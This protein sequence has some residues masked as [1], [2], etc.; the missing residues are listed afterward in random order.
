MAAALR[1]SNMAETNP[2]L[3]SASTRATAS[4][5]APV[6]SPVLQGQLNTAVADEIA[7]KDRLK[8]GAV[9]LSDKIAELAVET[10]PAHTA[11]QEAIRSKATATSQALYDAITPEKLQ[12]QTAELTSEFN[13]DVDEVQKQEAELQALRDTTIEKDG[14]FSALGALLSIPYQKAKVGA[15][16]GAA[17][18][19]AKL[20]DT[21]REVSTDAA[22]TVRQMEDFRSEAIIKKSNDAMIAAAEIDNAARAEKVAT[23]QADLLGKIFEADDKM[24]NTLISA[25]QAE[26]QRMA[27]GAAGRQEADMR[28][29]LDAKTAGINTFR[30]SQGQTELTADQ[31]Q[32]GLESQDEFS[33]E[34]NTQYA[35]GV[36]LLATGSP[37]NTYAEVIMRDA[38]YT[39]RLATNI[40][41][42]TAHSM[43]QERAGRNAAKQQIDYRTAPL[44]LQEQL[45]NEAKE[46]VVEDEQERAARG[47]KSMYSMQPYD[48]LAKVPAIA[49]DPVH[50]KVIAPLKLEKTDLNEIYKRVIAA[51][52]EKLITINEAAGYLEKLINTSKLVNNTVNQYERYKMPPQETVPYYLRQDAGPTLGEDVRNLF[53]LAPSEDLRIEDISDSSSIMNALIRLKSSYVARARAGTDPQ[54]RY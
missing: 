6:A 54:G 46:E 26:S 16:E 15:A 22:T 10:A 44:E 20:I 34:L 25:Q 5:R 40:P 27:I 17:D 45:L 36:N 33:K 2:I 49:D 4:S 11:V 48:V 42:N 52:Y 31:V 14:F 41:I 28:A 39:D 1:L 35:M 53:G 19:T 29:S 9:Q 8:T 24:L 18:R 21:T 47:E 13:A 38:K 37:G 23:T 43:I 12:Q 3:Q 7:S 30:K 32:A 50:Q 51:E